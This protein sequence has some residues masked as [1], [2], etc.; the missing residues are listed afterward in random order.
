MFRRS[1]FSILRCLCRV[2]H[3]T[4]TLVFSLGLIPWLY[5]AGLCIIRD[6]SPLPRSSIRGLLPGFQFKGFPF[7]V[8]FDL[9]GSRL[10][11]HFVSLLRS[12]LLKY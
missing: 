6:N 11:A 5:S 9:N 4:E 7:L 12:V 3:R 2:N 8:Y 1:V 10:N